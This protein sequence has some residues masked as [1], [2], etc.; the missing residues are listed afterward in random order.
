MSQAKRSVVSDVAAVHGQASP[1][2]IH[3]ALIRSI[4]DAARAAYD[5]YGAGASL[6][7]LQ[8][9][10]ARRLSAAGA[11][12]AEPRPFVALEARWRKDLG[13]NALDAKTQLDLVAA[14]LGQMA[15]LSIEKSQLLA[16]ASQLRTSLASATAATDVK[17][18]TKQLLLLS[19]KTVQTAKTEQELAEAIERLHQTRNEVSRSISQGLAND[20]DEYQATM[21]AVDPAA[22]KGLH[23][24]V[25]ELANKGA[26]KTN[27]VVEVIE[28]GRLTKAQV[29]GG[30]TNGTYKLSLWTEV[31]K[32]G[33]CFEQGFLTS[34][35]K[36]LEKPR[37]DI[38]AKSKQHQRLSDDAIAAWKDRAAL[39]GDTS[40]APPDAK[41]PEF[42]LLLLADA[43][44]TRPALADLCRRIEAAAPG[45]EATLG[46]I[47][48]ISRAAVKALT[49]YGGD[50]SGLTDLVRMKVVC[51]EL[52][53]VRR[54]LEE[55]ATAAGWELVLIKDRMQHAYDPQMSGGY[56]DILM[57][58]RWTNGHV[59]EVQFHLHK[60]IAIKSGG[61]HVRYELARLLGLF[62]PE[63]TSHV[64]I[65]T[66]AVLENISAGIVRQ[67]ECRGP[68]SCVAPHFG[69]LLGAIRSPACT[70]VQLR[71]P[72]VDWPP[73]RPVSELLDALKLR[74]G[75]LRS[76]GLANERA[77]AACEIPADF[78]EECTNIEFFN[79]SGSNITGVIPETVEKCSRLR[80][81]FV[82]DNQLSGEVPAAALASINTLKIMDIKGNPKLTLSDEGRERLIGSQIKGDWRQDANTAR[83]IVQRC[84]AG[85]IQRKRLRKMKDMDSE[86]EILE[87][88]KALDKDDSGTISA[89]ELRDIMSSQGE[90]FTEEE[91]EEIFREADTD[92][93][94]QIN[95]EEFVNM[96]SNNK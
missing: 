76:V 38:Y 21:D 19:T 91:A 93:D 37:K 43:D 12:P 1:M 66:E 95:Y 71:L 9:A 81:F 59:V 15:P 77:A 2:D 84:I 45:T 82:Q 26:L 50:Y 80:M 49:K 54:A 74:R 28:N 72:S 48:S 10:V 24:R 29:R 22:A 11:A 96:M 31:V 40:P 94:G 51:E 68:A 87:A 13:V 56:R 53:H 6:V 67:V 75:A 88:F 34:E 57:N 41:T 46:P 42:L 64:G 60:L 25:R 8:R 5:E 79:V 36:L 58:L 17:D 85:G 62:E 18:T 20:G 90:K 27:E 3:N 7:E 16:Q 89:A 47:K 61:G 83:P 65:L 4:S 33:H 78:F 30:P 55:A 52:A 14:V 86:K 63:T 73:G 23:E 44:R 35:P 39:M 70:L 32:P 92:G 69:G